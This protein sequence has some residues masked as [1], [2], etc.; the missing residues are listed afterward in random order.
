MRLVMRSALLALALGLVAAG[1][2]VAQQAVTLPTTE[3]PGLETGKMW[4][5]D[6]PPLEYWARRYNFRPDQQWL[7]HVRLSTARIPGCTSSFVSADGLIMTNHHCARGCVNNVSRQGEDL[8]ANGFYAQTRADERA[9]PNFVVD[10]LVEI[11]DV[12][13]QVNAAVPAG[14]SADRAA[15]LRGEASQAVQDRCDASAPNTHCEVIPMYRGGQYKLYRFR[16][17]T[18]ARLVFAPETQV[19]SFG[20]DPDNFT[21]PRHDLD[22]SFLRVY[23]NG[24]P[25]RAEHFYRWSANGSREGDLVFVVGNPGNTSRLQ[26]IAQLEYLRDVQYPA[27]LGQLGRQIAVAQELGRMS[28]DR[29]TALRNQLFGLQNTQKAVTGYQSGLLDNQL[30]ERKRQW[31]RGFRDRV[32]ANPELRRQYG[33]AWDNLAR[34]NREQATLNLRLRF[35]AFGAYGTRLLGFAGALVRMPVEMPKA[36]SARLFAY[37]DANRANVE[38]NLN[39]QV[40][41]DT[42]QEIRML[43]AYFTAMASELPATDPVL[44]Q[45]LGGRTPEAAARA[46]VTATQIGTT[47]Q[48][49]AILQGGAQAVAASTDPF[50]QLARVI[51]PLS[52]PIITR[53]TALGNEEAQNDELVAR[54]L[55]AVF[56]NSVAP[57]A[58][59]SLRISDGE[60][61]RYPY[62]GTMAQPYTTFYGLF[63][64]AISFNNEFPW[65]LSPRWL[66]ARERLNMATPFNAVS[67]N[68]ITGG[69]SGSPVVSRDGEIVGLIHDGNI[70][71]LPLDFIFLET[72]GGRSVWVDSRA[73]IES[74][75]RVYDAGTLADELTRRN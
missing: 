49:R 17:W 2:A 28:P 5:F 16:R 11:T 61:L 3:Y 51:D 67:T 26:T 13:A 14:A 75:R 15:T 71:Q 63:D 30:L 70:E 33:A 55:Q 73:I 46:M 1:A 21:Y 7:D 20:G 69:N 72:T 27:T 53:W 68:D 40:P 50:I 19:A 23:E 18:E 38:R 34:I 25:I 24:Q 52:R 58:T 29:A 35:Y 9:C 60:I 32:N 41:V 54:A 4:T 59:F 10:Q 44:R 22:M 57:D 62:N 47:E 6:V 74:L 8:L 66:A 45:A 42:T 56:G 31:E 36:D 65:T 39:S 43:A 64:R 37:R 48:R 12:T